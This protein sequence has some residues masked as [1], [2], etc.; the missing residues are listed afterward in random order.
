MPSPSSSLATQRPDLAASLEEFDL[1]MNQAGFVATAVFPV[2][3]VAKQAGNF[4][5]I[6]IEQLLQERETARAPGTGYARGNWNFQPATYACQEHGAEE[7]ID[8]R[9]R[10]MYADY[11]DAELIATRRAMSAV[12]V[13]AEKR[14]AAA[15]F[16]AS[17][18]TGSSLTTGVS[19][20]WSTADSATPIAD[21]HGAKQKVYDNSGLMANAAI[22]TWK[23][24]ENLRICDDIT[25]LVK[26]QNYMDARSGKMSMEGVAA[27]LGVE[28]L[29][30]AGGVKNTANEGKAASL[31]PIWD[32]EYC[33][34][35]RVA[36]SN[37][38]REPCIGRTFHWAGD[39]SQM[40]GRVESYREEQTRSDIV[41][42]RHDVDE[43]NL[44][45][46]AGHLL[47]NITE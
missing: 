12:M 27:A 2:I 9:E 29:I 23:V 22:M 46:E 6:P 30:I 25:S 39:G 18:W 44:Y 36:T 35:C 16:N 21:V 47:S 14:V 26:Y 38:F 24:F 43:V 17:T 34:V 45:T 8:D 32:D 15:V 20:E 42:V 41:R 5:K 33:M 4:G 11:F 31:S 37:D 19:T 7:P 13:N 10:Q 40:D 28:R 1:E 3:N